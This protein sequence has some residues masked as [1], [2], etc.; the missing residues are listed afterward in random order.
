MTDWQ[1]RLLRQADLEKTEA[2][3]AASPDALETRF[4]RACL[5][6]QLG[7]TEEAKSAFLDVLSRAPTHFGALNDFGNLLYAQGF[8]QAARSLYAEAVKHHPDNPKAHVNLA[9]L[10]V[11]DSEHDRAREHFEIALRLAPNLIEANRGLAYLATELRDETQAAQYR[12]KAFQQHPVL[13]MPYCGE[14]TPLELLVLA[15]AIGGAIPMRHHFDDRLFL[16]S[17]LFVEYYDPSVPLPP[18]Q[19]VVNIIG[20]A[21]LCRPA[22]EAAAQ[23]VAKTGAPVINRPSDVLR[24]GR[25]ENAHS[26]AQISHVVTP[27]MSLL[28]RARLESKDA[29]GLLAGQ[30]FAFPLLLR[31]PG[32]HTGRFFTRVENEQELAAT[33]GSMPG[34]DLLAI[35]YVDVR[36]R[37]GKIRKYRVMMIGGELYPLH[38]AI[39]HDWKI[40]YFTAE[41]A[42][43]P[44]HRA[45]DAAFLEDMALVLGPRA[46]G[47]LEEIC[48][49]LGL[50]YGGMDFSLN[51]AGEVVLFEANPSMVVSP[52]DKDA[53]WDYRRPAVQRIMAAVRHLLTHSA[54][55]P[56]TPSGSPFGKGEG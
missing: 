53:R 4:H 2:R 37:D 38:A 40:H 9:N 13:V 22:L 35:Q 18:H 5:L 50:D 1:P 47:A 12:Q 41:M 30:G 43:H 56:G 15:S 27:K 34:Q 11:G 10:L 39:S 31:A 52:P 26:L 48:R 16:V 49:T 7:R 36:S 17:A 42:D 21:D 25:A 55:P 44:E 46:I 24:T 51:A 14:G 19:R 45:E 28:P 6:A 29:P 32:F 23:I 33:V 8:R 20:D 54:R 3:L